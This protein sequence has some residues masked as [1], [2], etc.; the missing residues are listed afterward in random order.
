MRVTVNQQAALEDARL[1]IF[2]VGNCFL[3]Q[4]RMLAEMLGLKP[5]PALIV[6]TVAIST[7]QKYMRQ[8]VRDPAYRGSVPLPDALSGGISRRAIARATGLPTETVR[9]C[10][11]EMVAIGRLEI[12]TAQKVRT[13]PGSISWLSGEH[14]KAMVASVAR[15]ADTLGRAGVLEF[16]AS[17]QTANSA[18]GQA[19]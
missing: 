15:Q 4:H 16:S 17:R 18:P 1:V 9:R 14:L 11:E 2:E 6:L 8:N 13:P 7:V 12:L 3:L 19:K 5:V 10:V